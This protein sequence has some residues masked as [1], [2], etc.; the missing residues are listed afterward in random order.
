MIS[1]FILNQ[2]DSIG[3]TVWYVS[4][5]ELDSIKQLKAVGDIPFD[6]HFAAFGARNFRIDHPMLISMIGTVMKFMGL[7]VSMDPILQIFVHISLFFTL[8]TVPFI[9][10]LRRELER[11]NVQINLGRRP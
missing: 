8:P 5:V 9:D 4:L 1:K 3:N 7:R 11:R 10:L 2:I 6:G